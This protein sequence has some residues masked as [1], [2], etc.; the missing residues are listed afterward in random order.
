MRTT[1]ITLLPA[2][3]AILSPTHAGEPTRT[4]EAAPPRLHFRESGTYPFVFRAESYGGANCF[5]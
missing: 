3:C 4:R 2:I 1:S 5:L